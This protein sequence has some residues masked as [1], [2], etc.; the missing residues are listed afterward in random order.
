MRNVNKPQR[1]AK[2]QKIAKENFHVAFC[3]GCLQPLDNAS[4]CD[5]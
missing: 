5:F 3:G 1:T 4:Q 2:C